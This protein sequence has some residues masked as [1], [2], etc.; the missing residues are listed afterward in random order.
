[1]EDHVDVEGSVLNP[2]GR[3][4]DWNHS[5]RDEGRENEAESNNRGG[6]NGTEGDSEIRWSRGSLRSD[7]EEDSLGSLFCPGGLAGLS[8]A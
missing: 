6:E 5:R 3:N 4:G 7:A 2:T 8:I 1:M